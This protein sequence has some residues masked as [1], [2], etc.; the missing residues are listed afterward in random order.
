MMNYPF[1]N[2]QT[3][4]ITNSGKQIPNTKLRGNLYLKELGK[5]K[6]QISDEAVISLKILDEDNFEYLLNVEN[7]GIRGCQS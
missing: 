7:E 6:Q 4:L 2:F 5:P 3:G 1:N